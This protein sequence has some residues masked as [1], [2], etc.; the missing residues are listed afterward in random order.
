MQDANLIHTSMGIMKITAAITV[1]LKNCNE[2]TQHN[3][4]LEV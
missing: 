3:F 4:L 1:T 2:P